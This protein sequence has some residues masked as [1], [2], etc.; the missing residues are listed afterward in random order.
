MAVLAYLR[1]LGPFLNVI[2][3]RIRS[4]MTL[5]VTTRLDSYRELRLYLSEYTL[6]TYGFGCRHLLQTYSEEMNGNS[7]ASRTPE[8]GSRKLQH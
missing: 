2:L 5:F 4:S 3:R 6:S 7:K 1:V 8:T